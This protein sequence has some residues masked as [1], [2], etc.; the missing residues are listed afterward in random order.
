MTSGK[1]E[2]HVEARLGLSRYRD[3]NATW[4]E[5]VAAALGVKERTTSA[6]RMVTRTT[7][8]V[9]VGVLGEVGLCRRPERNTGE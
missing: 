6:A 4:P 2:R 3:Q 9:G 1:W 8:V 7:K 5:L